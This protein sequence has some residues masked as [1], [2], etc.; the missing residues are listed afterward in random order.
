M[1]MMVFYKLLLRIFLIELYWAP[2][3]FRNSFACHSS[4]YY[5]GLIDFV[6][7]NISDNSIGAF[8]PA[9]RIRNIA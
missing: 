9:K 4:D 2:L 5:L 7:T 3:M 8:H 1:D 6:I